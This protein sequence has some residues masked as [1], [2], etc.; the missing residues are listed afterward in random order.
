[1]A[2][3]T[4]EV[5]VIVTTSP[6]A[7][8]SVAPSCEELASTEKSSSAKSAWMISEAKKLAVSRSG[9]RRSRGSRSK[10]TREIK[11]A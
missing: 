9:Y 6:P 8:L 5:R 1:L 10:F 7:A 4:G 11:C 3:T 2:T